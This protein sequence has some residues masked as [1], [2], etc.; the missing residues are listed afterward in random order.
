MLI[1]QLCI[2]TFITL[3]IIIL[4]FFLIFF[5]SI[6]NYSIIIKYTLN[7]SNYKQ[8]TYLFH[9]FFKCKN[10]TDNGNESILLNNIKKNQK[11]PL[12]YASLIID[13]FLGFTFT[14]L[15]LIYKYKIGKKLERIIGI[16]GL[17]GLFLTVY[18]IYNVY[19]FKNNFKKEY[20]INNISSSSSHSNINN[21]IKIQNPKKEISSFNFD[22]LNI[23]KGENQRNFYYWNFREIETNKDNIY[24][25]I[26]SRMAIRFI[27]LC[28]NAI[29]AILGY[30]LYKNGKS[31]K[32]Q[33]FNGLKKLK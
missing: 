9:E 8:Y 22:N 3:I 30:L 23:Y 15:P 2:F 19:N 32:I 17:I 11:N 1:S 26:D 14:L 25:Y 21:N 33:K 24:N 6:I 12:E 13:I 7:L 20:Y 27:I 16:G 10:L 18:N 28:L 4:T 29:L 31:S 5:A